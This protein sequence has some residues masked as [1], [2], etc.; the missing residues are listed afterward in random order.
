VTKI[1]VTLDYKYSKGFKPLPNDYNSDTLWDVQTADVLIRTEV[2]GNEKS[3]TDHRPD[4]PGGIL[5]DFNEA[6]DTI[7]RLMTQE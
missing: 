5:A 1:L 6:S 3:A 4:R 7:H 2:N